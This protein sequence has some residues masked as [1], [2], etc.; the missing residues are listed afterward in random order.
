MIIKAFIEKDIFLK[1]GF[2]KFPAN[3]F[4]FEVLLQVQK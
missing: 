1:E 3:C 2:Y 4:D